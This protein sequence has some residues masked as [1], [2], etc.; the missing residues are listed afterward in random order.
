MEIALVTVLI[1]NGNIV[2]AAW[3]KLSIILANYKQQVTWTKVSDVANKDK[4][5]FP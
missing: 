1:R 4:K 5:K 2:E 3:W